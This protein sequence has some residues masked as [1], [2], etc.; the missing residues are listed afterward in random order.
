[1]TKVVFG[2]TM[3]LD[4]FIN[5]RDGNAGKLYPDLEALDQ[6][7]LMQ[8]SIRETGAVIMGRKTFEM[9]SAADWYAEDYEYQVP[10]FVV[11][12]TPPEKHPHENG[13][14]SFTFLD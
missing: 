11:T 3:S 12:S 7:E 14:I 6:T 8:E 1:M 10:N 5:N 13:R 2:M 9:A 4:G